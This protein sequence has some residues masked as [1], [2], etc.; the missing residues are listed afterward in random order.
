MSSYQQAKIALV[1]ATGLS[2][3]ALHI[4]VALVVFFGGC[5]LF[6]WK[7]RQWRPLLLVLAAAIAG[8]ALDIRDTL[9]A[10]RPAEWL[11]TA[12]DIVNT[13]IMPTTILL[14]ARLSGIFRND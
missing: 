7:A 8:E 11:D 6:G 9:A 12:K 2:R 14:T 13:L 10:G 5:L 1:D 3:D 4:Y